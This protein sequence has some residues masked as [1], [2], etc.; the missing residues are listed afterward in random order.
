M[1][2]QNKNP[3]VE[4]SPTP[5]PTSSPLPGNQHPIYSQPNTTQE[6]PI[7]PTQSNPA[8]S[9]QLKSPPVSRPDVSSI[10]PEATVGIGAT[11][12]TNHSLPV[13]KQ[14]TSKVMDFNNGYSVG[15]TIF[16]FQLLVGIVLG[17]IFIGINS[18]LLKHTTAT[19]VGTVSLFYYVFELATITYIPYH[20]LKSNDVENPFWLTLFGIATQSVI[21]VIA[22]EVVDI[23]LIRSIIN[24]GLTSS[25]SHIGGTGLGVAA[26]LIYLGFLVLTYF[27]IK[28]SWAVA[29]SLFS[30]IKNKTIVKAI[31]IIIIALVIIGIGH[32]K[33][34]SSAGSPVVNAINVSVSGTNY[35]TRTV[36]VQGTKFTLDFDKSAYQRPQGGN[37]PDLAGVD[38]LKNPMTLIMQEDNTFSSLSTCSTPDGSASGFNLLGSVNVIGQTTAICGLGASSGFKANNTVKVDFNYAQKGYSL[39]LIMNSPSES[40]NLSTVNTI[41]QSIEPTS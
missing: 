32:A 13:D 41:A 40:V 30:K 36:D 10:Y 5:Q 20:T 23:I 6:H 3:N 35:T 8:T 17:L 29:F 14:D 37:E 16:W 28:L 34:H 15:G 31:G 21:L 1:D 11:N 18:S 33:L 26:I 27:L 38:L 19:T 9:D 7:D 22:F 12:F 2:D 25:I 24:H 39:I 4:S